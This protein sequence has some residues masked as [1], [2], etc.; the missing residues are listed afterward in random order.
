MMIAARPF[1][2]C[3]CL[4]LAGGLANCTTFPDLDA[5]QTP[6]VADA[7]YPELLALDDLL[8]GRV[9]STSLAEMTV[10][11]NRVT[12]LRSR[13][14]WLLRTDPTPNSVDKRVSRLRQKADAL[15][16]Q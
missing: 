8:N 7:P 4:A 5:V 9:A 12:G 10:V 15:R 3:L 11:E 14:D 6:G 13:A 1:R 16:S 2:L